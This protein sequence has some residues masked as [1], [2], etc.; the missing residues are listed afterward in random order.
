MFKR[1]AIANSKPE[2]LLL[3][4]GRRVYFEGIICQ[5]VY[6]LY[7]QEM[8]LYATQH[9]RVHLRAK[10]PV[11]NSWGMELLITQVMGVARCVGGRRCGLGACVGWLHAYGAEVGWEEG[12]QWGGVGKVEWYKGRWTR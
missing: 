11:F 10:M 5:H 6:M 4:L 12:V 2:S 1:R 9:L 8:R 3:R 7:L